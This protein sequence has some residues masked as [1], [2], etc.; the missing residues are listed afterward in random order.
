MVKIKRKISCQTYA[1]NSEIHKETVKCARL[2]VSYKKRQNISSQL[3]K[4]KSRANE[5]QR[6]Q[7]RAADRENKRRSLADKGKRM[8]VK[9][10]DKRLNVTGKNRTKYASIGQKKSTTT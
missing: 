5:E 4:R 6:M 7:H 1:A 3:S 8:L 2:C 10:R 9:H